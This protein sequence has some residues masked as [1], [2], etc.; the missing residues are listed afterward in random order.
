VPLAINHP[1]T[2]GESVM[3]PHEHGLEEA[4]RVHLIHK[5]L[6]VWKF[7]GY[8]GHLSG[9]REEDAHRHGGPAPEQD[10]MRAQHREWVSMLP[11]FDC[12]DVST[13]KRWHYR[14]FRPLAFD[15]AARVLTRI[16]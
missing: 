12:L 3:M 14:L 4:S 2:I 1:Q 16:A 8:N 5:P 6:T 7:D 9:V 13:L 15:G 10:W 11:P